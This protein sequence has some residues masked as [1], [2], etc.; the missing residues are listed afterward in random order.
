MTHQL[1]LP[2][3]DIVLGDSVEVAFDALAASSPA[4]LVRVTRSFQSRIEAHAQGDSG[5]LVQ[6]DDEVLAAATAIAFGGRF[7]S[8]HTLPE[9]LRVTLTTHE[10]RSATLAEMQPQ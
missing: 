3:G 6:E 7:R 1:L 8:R 5:D 9:Q 4:A 2:I 10:S